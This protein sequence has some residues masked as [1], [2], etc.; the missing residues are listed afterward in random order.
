M[1]DSSTESLAAWAGATRATIAIVF[2][3]VVDSTALGERLGDETMDRL[4]SAHFEQSRKLIAECGGRPIKSLGDGDLAVFRTVE[5]AL[6]FTLALRAAPGHPEISLRACIHIGPVVILDDDIRGRE[7]NFTARVGS[8]NKGAQIWISDIAMG[9]IRG[10]RAE[11][12]QGL[13][14]RRHIGVQLKGFD[15]RFLLWSLIDAANIAD[16]DVDERPF[17]RIRSEAIQRTPSSSG[18]TPLPSAKP[19]GQN[20]RVMAIIMAAV[21]IVVVVVGITWYAAKR[22]N[23]ADLKPGDEFSDCR[24]CPSMKVLPVGTFSMGS[25]VTENKNVHELP[26]HNV[27]IPKSFA[28]GKFEVTNSQYAEFLTFLL[29]EGNFDQRFATTTQQD[30]SSPLMFKLTSIMVPP[31]RENH[32]VAGVSWPGAQAY[33]QWLSSQTGY[34]YRLPS[35]AEW[36]YA[37]RAGTETKWF[38]GDDNLKLCE[39]ANVP[40]RT[41]QEANPT[42]SAIW[43]TDGYAGTSPVGKFKPNP[44][45]LYDMVGNVLEWV[46]DCWHDDYADAPTDGSAWV[47]GG[48]CQNRVTRGG[49]Y[50][51][52][53][54]TGSGTRYTG[55]SNTRWKTVGFRVARSLSE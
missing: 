21:T 8:A 35:E 47:T 45:G 49:S 55:A 50:E 17:A 32:P 15:G 42:W 34:Q 26:A 12:H 2:T 7:V 25:S 31:G 36:E 43:C 4:W 54:L 3:D 22:P 18:P 30:A 52:F 10:L 5:A 11:R 51:V 46:E 29:K 20:H 9:H 40:D 28:I 1:S 6:D 13:R 24:T 41:H 33:V 16:A 27:S 19:Q 23:V 37:E 38:F 53:W 48:D 44:F 39:F 14:W